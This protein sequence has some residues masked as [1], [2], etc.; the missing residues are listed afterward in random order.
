MCECGKSFHA[1]TGLRRHIKG[2]CHL[3]KHQKVRLAFKKEIPNK[4]RK[5]DKSGKSIATVY[6]L[7]MCIRVIC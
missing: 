1:K 4:G 6:A 7:T 2:F 5:A 3:Q